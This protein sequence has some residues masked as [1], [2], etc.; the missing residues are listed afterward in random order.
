[1]SEMTFISLD[2]FRAQEDCAPQVFI[3]KVWKQTLADGKKVPAR[4]SYRPAT[5]GD[6]EAAREFANRFGKFNSVDYA[7]HII[8]LCVVSPKFS[9]MDLDMFRK[10]HGK[11]MDRL[12]DAIMGEEEKNPR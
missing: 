10:R 7:S 11:E 9:E 3:S 2:E 12:F 4:I 1:M 8:L 5:V 6:K